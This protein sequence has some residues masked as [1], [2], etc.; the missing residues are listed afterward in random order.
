MVFDL[1]EALHMFSGGIVLHSGVCVLPH[2]VIDGRHDVQHLLQSEV[3]KGENITE[4][5]GNN[6]CSLKNIY[7]NT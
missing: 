7:K 2:H 6:H 5:S 4:D 1:E 3:E